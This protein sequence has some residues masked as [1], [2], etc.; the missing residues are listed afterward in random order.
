MKEENETEDQKEKGRIQ[1]VILDMSSKFLLFVVLKPDKNLLICEAVVYV[2]F[3]SFL[4]IEWCSFDKMIVKEERI[5]STSQ[6][7]IN[8][9]FWLIISNFSYDRCDKYR[10][11]GNSC[12][13]RNTQEVVFVW[14]RS[15]ASVQFYLF[16]F[17]LSVRYICKLV[18]D[19]NDFV[20]VRLQ[21]A[22]ANPRWQVIHRLK[23]AKLLDII[24]G[25]RV[26]LTVGEAV[27]ACLNPKVAGGSSCWWFK[28][29]YWI[30]ITSKTMTTP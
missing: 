20:Y 25:E 22:M 5:Y 23:V 11:F 3:L 9:K 26:F 10:H 14:H 29:P 21:L 2:L 15:K 4:S 16:I 8:L 27:D 7:G 13:R 6:R 30:L 18:M 28:W 19:F 24:G 1:H 17:F 12:T